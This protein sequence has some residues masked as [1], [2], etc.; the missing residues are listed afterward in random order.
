MVKELIFAALIVGD[1]K[2]AT[3][4]GRGCTCGD[5]RG[6]EPGMTSYNANSD[7]EII[8]RI[9]RDAISPAGR[10]RAFWIGST[11]IHPK[12]TSYDFHL[13]RTAVKER[14]IDGCDYSTEGFS[15]R[16]KTYQFAFDKDSVPID[17]TGIVSPPGSLRVPEADPKSKSNANLWN[18]IAEIPAEGDGRRK[19]PLQIDSTREFNRTSW[20]LA[21]TAI[22]AHYVAVV[23]DGYRSERLVPLKKT[24]AIKA[25]QL[26]QI[27]A[28]GAGSAIVRFYEGF[29]S[30]E[31]SKTGKFTGAAKAFRR[32][33]DRTGG[34]YEE[35]DDV[36]Y[37][38]L[39]ASILEVSL[40]DI[41]EVNQ[42]LDQKQTDR[43]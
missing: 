35:S 5:G 9:D 26:G 29:R 21:R 3:E 42:Y 39:G 28:V 10:C 20:I 4:D 31:G 37:T 17:E 14:R 27:E 11:E 34:P 30:A 1:A 19:V 25:G 33:Y 7:R 22:E 15:R 6:V 23:K 24:R 13:E 18:S 8:T 12:G 2:T 32:W 36:L 40:D 16:T 38:P 43:T 41:I